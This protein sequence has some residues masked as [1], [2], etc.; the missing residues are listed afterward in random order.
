LFSASYSNQ[1]SISVS[2]LQNII[3]GQKE[4]ELLLGHKED[5]FSNHAKLSQNFGLSMHILSGLIGFI[6]GSF[7][8]IKIQDSTEILIEFEIPFENIKTK[9]YS[10]PIDYPAAK[11]N[12]KRDMVEG[13]YVLSSPV[14]N[15]RIINSSKIIRNENSAEVISNIRETI[16]NASSVASDDMNT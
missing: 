4:L 6:G 14:S 10:P 13:R 5:L 7:N 1:N 15:H 16:K 12:C 9:P 3:L 11:G 8:K 2:I